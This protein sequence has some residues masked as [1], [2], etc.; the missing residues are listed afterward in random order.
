MTKLPRS[1]K[2]EARSQKGAPSS[3]S[4]LMAPELLPDKFHEECG[5]V[6][7]YGH[8]EAA[9]LAYLGLYALQH[10]GQ[11]SA[12][13]CTAEG[14]EIHIHKAMGHVADIFTSNVLTTLPGEF[15]IGHTRYSTAGDTV[16]LN[17]QPF[18]VQCNKGR[19][20]VAHNGNITNAAELR[21][22]LE[23]R[24]AIFQASSDTEVILHLVAHSK[25]R[26]L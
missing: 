4:W 21:A 11:E 17:A 2:S 16:L 25:E 23:R 19:I 9:K 24:G 15:A 14:G 26:T 20:A 1:P 7:I 8:P 12:G 22:D 6:A 13:I 3:D 10:R 5:V 18:S